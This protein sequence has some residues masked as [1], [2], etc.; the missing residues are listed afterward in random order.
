[1]FVTATAPNALLQQTYEA[2][3]LLGGSLLPAGDAP[4]EGVDPEQWRVLGDWLALAHRIGAEHVFFVDDDPVVVFSALEPDASDTD[5]LEAYRRAWSLSRPRCLFVARGD[6]LRVYALAKPPRRRM[7]GP[8]AVEPIEIVERAADVGAALVDFHRDRLENGA[9]FER[10]EFDR[11]RGAE[12][13]LLKDVRAASKQLVA[14]GLKRVTAHALIERVVLIRYL[15]DREVVMPG[16]LQQ[17]AASRPE[18][19]AALSAARQTPNLGAQSAF[20]WCLGDKDLTYAVFERLA[21]EFNGDL[22]LPVAAELDE[23]TGRHLSL[24]QQLL[25]GTAASGAPRLFLWAYDFGVV[26]TSLISTMYEIFYQE[27]AGGRL[28]GTHYT[29]PALVEHVLRRALS[30][31]TLA[32]RPKIC[33]PACGSGIFLVGAFRMIV[34]HQA[35]RE[36]QVPRRPELERILDEQIGGI[37]VNEAAIRL[38]AFS[39]LLAFLDYQSPQDIRKAGPLPRLIRRQPTDIGPLL[40]ANAFAPT[41]TEADEG[42]AAEGHLPLPWQTG[43]FDVVIGNPPWSDPRPGES[44][45]P[46]DW[47]KANGLPVDERSRSQ[48][49]LW[50]ALTLL[51]PGGAG[52]MLVASSTLMSR[53]S[54]KERFRDSWVQR[55]AIDYVVDFTQARRLFFAGA[56]AP[57]ALVGFR[58]GPPGEHDQRFAYE[59][60]IATQALRRAR[61]MSFARVRRRVVSQD[62]VLSR[63]YLW[64]LYTWG[65]HHDAALMARL[66]LEDRLGDHVGTDPAPGWGYQTS[67]PGK[68]TPTLKALRSLR[69]VRPWGP[70]LDEWLEPP[71]TRANRQPDER[72]YHG[73]RIL[74]TNGIATRFG[75]YPRLEYDSYSHRHVIYCIP[76][77]N[78]PA[79]KAKV[80]LGTLLSSLGRYRLF[81]TSGSWAIWHDKVNAEELLALP[82]RFDERHPATARMVDAVERLPAI[83]GVEEDSLFDGVLADDTGLLRATLAEMDAAAFDLFGLTA[84]ERELVADFWT[85]FSAEVGGPAPKLTGPPI[86]PAQGTV[87]DISATDPL[88][89]YLR[90]FLHQWNGHLDAVEA[91]LT[92]QLAFDERADV[93]VA[94]FRIMRR[95]EH[96]E[97]PELDSQRWSDVLRRLGET[98][99]VPEEARMP[100]LR[101]GVLRAVSD[102]AIAIARPRE[103]AAWTASSAREDAEATI[104]QAT[105]LH[106]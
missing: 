37:D 76:L 20:V 51:R 41:S 74:V 27:D 24:I 1:L 61:T 58:A 57:F 83:S 56:V 45:L 73:Q 95:G 60:V 25:L 87:A 69:D 66:D 91:E 36:G 93:V 13:Q 15:E 94:V 12:P 34:R 106:G 90:S 97:I 35:A 67:A 21:E 44:Q 77:P 78:E 50:R 42:T 40:V 48:L 9:A 26:P 63:D 96:P 71:P 33:D 92:W 98:A 2:L 17:I 79:W 38:A 102:T 53:R 16:Y 22:F 29:P 70:V 39:L 8:A 84:Y 62:A 19:V 18:W 104:L 4:A 99:S 82:V 59:T 68:P 89:R 65:N 3:D 6:E 100:V 11:A 10:E 64:R 43:H 52:S 54:T 49:F 88:S 81:M 86:A 47:A 105:R 80:L 23:V 31:A 14:A 28:S 85:R 46:D 72:L 101:T 7:D 5:V 55:V 103:T 32:S 75:P 30:E